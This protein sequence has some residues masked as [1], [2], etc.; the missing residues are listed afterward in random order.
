MGKF[1]QD[2]HLFLD[3]VENVLILELFGGI[4]VPGFRVY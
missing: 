3:V 1:L 4:D 2:A